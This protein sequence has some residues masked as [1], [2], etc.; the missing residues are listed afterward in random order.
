MDVLTDE[1]L[2]LAPCG[3]FEFTDD[4][5]LVR[6]NT[7]LLEQL[8]FASEELTGR[9]VETLFTLANRI[10]YQTHFFPLLK[11]HGR[12]EE[13]FVTL[14]A[15]DGS[16]L[17][18][19]INAVRRP[20]ESG[21]VNVCVAI[22]VRQ[23]RKY[24]DEILQAKKVAQ[25]ALEENNEL[26]TAKEQLEAHRYILDHKLA[27]FKQRNQD[28]IQLNRVITHD[29]QEPLR[30]IMLFVDK[31]RLDEGIRL[32]A[33]GEQ[34]IERITKASRLLK[35]LISGLREFVTFDVTENPPSSVD[36]NQV[37]A[38]ARDLVIRETGFG[39]VDLK[40]SELPVI[41]GFGEQLQLLFYHLLSNS[42]KFRRT[43]LPTVRVEIRSS[44]V[45]DN[46]FRILKDRYHYVD[47][48]R[49]VYTDEGQGFDTRYT[50]GLFQIRKKLD[51]RTEG[52]GF[53]LAYCKKI[54]ENHNGSIST[55]SEPGKGTR[56]IILLPFRQSDQAFI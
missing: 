17:P 27:L 31:L 22:P 16:D 40:M 2:D 35:D 11:L 52:L 23:R 33:S 9:N 44:I 18:V 19:L 24:E 38:K 6:C 1:A 49:L 10:F 28:L 13:I 42:V 20:A 43:D 30:K 55:E 39:A 12:A 34:V 51:A 41:E 3:Y 45:Q 4:G 47:F 53:G 25:K 56:F 36:L 14:R 7:T 5:N 37:V 26:I 54:V 50:P 8:G 46:Q 32:S 21:F 29:L 15:K 48:V